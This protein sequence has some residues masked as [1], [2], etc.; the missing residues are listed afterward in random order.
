M[1]SALNVRLFLLVPMELFPYEVERAQAIKAAVEA[2]IELQNLH[3][4]D[5]VQFALANPA[6][7]TSLESVIDL[8]KGLQAFKA[9]YKIQDNVD[10]AIGCLT[11]FM[12]DFPGVFV[13][14]N[15]CVKNGGN[16]DMIFDWAAL[17]P[18]KIQTQEQK[19]TFF[20]GMYYA[21][22]SG[23]PTF[24]AM[25]RGT[26]VFVGCKEASSENV[27][28]DFH[29]EVI[30]QLTRNYPMRLR[31]V[32]AAN[33]PLDIVLSYGLCKRYMSPNFRKV[34]RLG[35][36]FAHGSVLDDYHYETPIP[37]VER[38][39]CVLNAFKLVLAR[40]LYKDGFSLPAM[41][42]GTGIGRQQ[43]T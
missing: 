40:T 22:H 10:E 42:T 19:D 13:N 28:H 21:L 38:V 41:A 8:I 29:V 25:R 6:S 2:D 23:S 20:R 26:S 5:Y 4:F 33:A 12:L 7:E 35:D 24:W 16:C 39:R 27:D 3:D 36:A 32:H 17:Y 34:F 37:M 18:R 31:E 1:A 15:F 14:V 9:E 11:A 30:H 43:Q